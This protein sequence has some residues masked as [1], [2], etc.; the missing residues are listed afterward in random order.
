MRGV[1]H[2]AVVA[3]LVV[4]AAAS[5]ALAAPAQATAYRYWSYWHD[6]GSGWQFSQI[7]AQ[8]AHPAD[9]TVEGWRFA[10]SPGTGSAPPPRTD[11][12]TAFTTLCSSTAARSGMKRV[13]LVVDFGVVTDAP[14]GDPPP[15]KP[16]HGSCVQVPTSA[17]GWD[18]LVKAGYA[19]R[20]DNGLV[21][22]LAGYPTTGCGEA[23]ADPPATP[24]SPT[25]TRTT[26]GAG[27]ASGS[28]R[29]GAAGAGGT[30]TVG[31]PGRTTPTHATALTTSGSGN[32]GD[33]GD[34]AG[35]ATGTATSGAPGATLQP[36]VAGSPDPHR[37]DG[38]TDAPT[39]GSAP[40]L[41][42]G[43]PTTAAAHGGSPLL[44][45]LGAALVAALAGGAVVRARRA[46]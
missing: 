14:S 27:H 3:A 43:A 2:G 38:A 15:A 19:I 1:R 28:T 39:P 21:C 6:T 24:P 9:G 11:T 26:S 31:T 7:G 16:L 32:H 30:G 20:S 4:A 10:I 17:T 22:G 25:P 40:T 5:V 34:P 33:P 18:V 42:E 23:V 45:L 12:T 37:T 44:V 41:V 46:R 29:G 35:R 8:S 36:R 13:G